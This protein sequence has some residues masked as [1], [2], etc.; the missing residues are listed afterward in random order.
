MSRSTWPSSR[1]NSTVPEPDNEVC[2]SSLSGKKN[3]SLH[4]LPLSL[5]GT[6]NWKMLEIVD[7]T[8]HEVDDPYASSGRELST[9]IIR[10]GDSH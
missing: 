7:V 1:E 9:G 2:A 8:S 3:T 4:V 5:D 10:S 6:W